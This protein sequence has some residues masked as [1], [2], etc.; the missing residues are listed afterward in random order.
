MTMKQ[1]FKIGLA[2]FLYSTF[3]LLSGSQI[4]DFLRYQLSDGRRQIDVSCQ[5]ADVRNSAVCQLPS[6]VYITGPLVADVGELCVF[7]LSD[8]DIRADWTVIRQTELESQVLYYIDTSGSALTFSSSVPAKYTIVAAIV[9][10]GNPKILQHVCLYGLTP[11]PDPSP[12][13]N[14]DPNP[15]PT[16]E[17]TPENLTEWVRQNIPLAGREQSAILAS[18]YETTADAIERGTIRTQ[19]AAF[20]SIRA[21]T[22]AKIKP[23]TWEKFLDELSAQI[24]SKLDGSTEIKPLGALFREIAIGLKIKPE[25]SIPSGAVC[26]DPTGAA[27]QPTPTIRSNSIFTRIR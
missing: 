18:I 3:L 1:K 2:L 13:P 23:G 12:T 8:A 16:P 15:S 10:E 26:P 5:T 11:Y 20:S 24:Q 27:C 7:R 14:P 9:D 22:Q 25:V 6:T 17:P 19:A 21:N 4:N